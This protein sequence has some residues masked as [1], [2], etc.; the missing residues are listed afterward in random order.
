[1]RL[2]PI[3][4]CV[5]FLL[6]GS[7][8]KDLVHPDP[9]GEPEFGVSALMNGTPMTIEA[10]VD[11]Y[12]LY[13]YADTG[14]GEVWTAYGTLQKIDCVNCNSY[15][16][17]SFRNDQAGYGNGMSA[18]FLK[19]GDIALTDWSGVYEESRSVVRFIADPT[20]QNGTVVSHFWNFGDGNTSTDPAPIH[21]F[22]MQGGDS[23][24]SVM[25]ITTLNGGCSAAQTN[26]INAKSECP[27]DFEIYVV[28]QTV[29]F[30][31]LT[32]ASGMYTYHWQFGDTQNTYTSNPAHIYA[33]PGEYNVLLTVENTTLGCSSS[34]SKKVIVGQAGCHANFTYVVDE[35]I[36]PTINPEQVGT[37]KLRR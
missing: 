32:I 35:I 4:I 3:V 33:A 16:S 1:M 28:G 20:N 21:T 37:D 19:A 29:Y 26:T 30:N 34:I 11:D 13:T 31:P 10:G 9:N 22:R 36:I 7:C 17:L 15:F 14:F 18:N 6:F 24:F 12:F 2:I 27:V 23:A 8:R 25:H 5:L